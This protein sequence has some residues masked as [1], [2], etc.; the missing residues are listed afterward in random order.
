MKK[1]WLLGLGFFS[2]SLTWALYNAFVPLFLDDFIASVALV[3]FLMTIDNYFGLFLQPI[4]GRQSD[5]TNTKIGKRMPYLALG[6]PLAAIFCMLIPMYKSE[7][8]VSYIGEPLS[9]ALGFMGDINPNLTLLVIFMVLMNISMALYRSPTV[10]LMPD[11]T[12]SEKHTQANGIINLMGG[13]GSILAFSI[14]SLLYDINITFP[15]ILSAVLSLFSLF[16]LLHF[17]KEKQLSVHYT[18]SENIHNPITDDVMIHVQEAATS[19]A[20]RLS[21]MRAAL[22]K[23]RLEWTRSTVLLLL[24]IYFWFFSY[25]GIEALFTLYSTNRL[26]LTDGQSGFMLTFFS[27]SFLAMAIPAG[28][29]GKKIGKKKTILIGVTGLIFVFGITGFITD[30]LL[31]RIL[32]IFGGMFWAFININSY[33]FVISLGKE[34]SIGTRTGIYYIASS[35]A[36]L[37]SPVLMGFF[38]DLFGYDYL[39]AFATIGLTLA[40][41]FVSLVNPNEKKQAL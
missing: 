14:G 20:T 27:L 39:F 22:T 18:K 7:L 6:I 37:S 23:Y 19:R 26:G 35:L 17:I 32:L 5:K 30:I 8:L 29:L 28:I 41:L 38:V 36:A 25:Q 40:L 13:I 2:I 10:S 33:P 34:S 15:F 12:P 9:N 11:I 24:A 1:V 4:I 16:M 21:N 3:G 31:V